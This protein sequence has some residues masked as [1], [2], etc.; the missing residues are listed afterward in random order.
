MADAKQGAAPAGKEDPKA[1]A[2]AKPAAS[3]AAKKKKLMMIAV[4]A[5]LL[6]GGGGG[7][8]FMLHKKPPEA[9][10][11]AP[12]KEEPKKLPNFVDMDQVTVNLADKEDGHLMQIK[13]SLEVESGEA[14]NTIKEMGPAL[15]AQFLLVLG[16][17]TA[18][19]MGTREGKEALA[20]ELMAVANKVLEP[21]PAAKAVTAVHITQLIIQ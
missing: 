19:E 2:A 13:F 21:T 15:R 12:K 9:G 4:A 16:S 7:A 3:P 11:E 8:F 6:L 20:K 10:A 14:E 5:L 1:A 17:H 18:A